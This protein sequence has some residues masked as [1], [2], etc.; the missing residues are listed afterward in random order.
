MGDSPADS[1][2]EI[3]DIILRGTGEK[4]QEYLTKN[5]V[6]PVLTK[7]MGPQ[8]RSLLHFAAS[9]GNVGC[10]R[11]LL[12]KVRL[13]SGWLLSTAL[14]IFSYSSLLQPGELVNL[15]DQALDTP[16]HLAVAC[17]EVEAVKLLLASGANVNIENG[18]KRKPLDYAKDLNI[19]T[20]LKS[21]QSAF[22]NEEQSSP[23]EFAH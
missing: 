8:K 11:V 6:K 15:Q 10:L 19:Q 20:L 3:V 1:E 4:L 22:F 23:L 17:G 14:F 12:Q 9:V 2:K 21:T 13:S 5:G 16:L 7:V 18:L